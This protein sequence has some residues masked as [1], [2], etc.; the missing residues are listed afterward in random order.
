M[1]DHFKLYNDDFHRKN[2]L[3]LTE[4]QYTLDCIRDL[5]TTS[6]IFSG[7]EPLARND[8]FEI[9]RYGHSI[10]L[11]AG[12]LTSGV[13]RDYKCLSLDEAKIISD[14]SSW[15]QLS[16]DSF[17]SATYNKIR[18]HEESKKVLDIALD[19][20]NAL[21]RTGFKDIEVC[22]TIQKDNIQEVAEISDALSR[23]LPPT[24]PIR[25]KFVHGPD[26]GRD[27]LCSVPQLEEAIRNLPR[28]PDRFNSKYIISMMEGGYFN[29]DGLS[30]GVPL[31]HKML[32]Y[33][34]LEYTC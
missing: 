22:F 11:R 3:T 6:V 13:M 31:K 29:F 9:L 4:L 2:E 32:E 14:M 34:Q 5:G 1:C 21:A 12:I 30:H 23:L 18:Q 24:V 8:F 16:I 26:A 15:I 17:D 33:N 28:N 19:S 27:F 25:F 10:G 20:V 7:G